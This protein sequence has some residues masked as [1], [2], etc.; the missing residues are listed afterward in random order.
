M[1]KSALYF[2]F[3]TIVLVLMGVGY[4]VMQGGFSVFGD[5]TAEKERSHNEKDMAVLYEVPQS[6]LKSNRYVKDMMPT[7]VGDY[8]VTS[9]GIRMTL[10]KDEKLDT[11]VDNGAMKY[12]VNRIQVLKNEARTEQA[13][14][15]VRKSMNVPDLSKNYTSAQI[16]Y[17]VKNESQRRVS[18]DGVTTVSYGYGNVMTPL[19]GL[20]NGG[21][22]SADGINPGETQS[23]YV[24]VWIPKNAAQD[25]KQFSIEFA[26]TYDET[27]QQISSKAPKTTVDF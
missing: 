4:V 21:S 2:T 14:S 10:D 20:V 16:D 12:H 3:S 18:S 24:I 13:Q 6:D 11:S 17:T 5:R 23:G 8:T 15:V 26:S 19:G 1:K 7:K 22:V 25:F 9:Q 27:G